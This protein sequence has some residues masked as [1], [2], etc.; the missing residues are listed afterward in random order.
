M[1]RTGDPYSE[2]EDWISPDFRFFLMNL[3]KVLSSRVNKES[4][5]GIMP[6]ST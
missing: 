6:F 5:R 2:F 1:K 3:Y 4:N